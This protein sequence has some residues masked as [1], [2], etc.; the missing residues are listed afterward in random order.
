MFVEQLL[1]FFSFRD[2]TFP[3]AEG[4]FKWVSDTIAI[5]PKLVHRRLGVDSYLVLRYTLALLKALLWLSA[6]GTSSLSSQWLGIVS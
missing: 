2:T 4:L 6:L 3:I 5:D 1:L